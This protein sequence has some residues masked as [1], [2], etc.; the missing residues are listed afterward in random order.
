MQE[1]EVIHQKEI[2]PKEEN[3]DKKYVVHINNF[4]GPL[5]LLWN[6]IKKAK[7]DII[8]ISISE[9]TEQYIKYLKLMENLN[10]SIAAEFI[11]MASELIFYKS[12]ALLPVSEIED[13]YFVPQLPPELVKKLLEYKKYQLASKDLMERAELQSEAYTRE[14]D[15]S[16]FIDNEEYVTMSLFDLLNAF[17]DTLGSAKSVEE[18]E[19]KFDEILVSDRIDYIVNTLKTKKEI[20]FTQLFQNVSGI[21][22]VVVTFLAVLELIKVQ[23]IKIMQK[24]NFGSI[25]IFRNFDPDSS[26]KGDD[27]DLTSAG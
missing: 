20:E 27:L 22:M 10:V 23:K 3:N 7:I 18:R 1:H 13:E 19:I 8:D 4:E 11:N 6:L 26:I 25:H 9:I 24:V 21:S 12:R 14:S 16:E 5:D 2:T 15:L 17:V